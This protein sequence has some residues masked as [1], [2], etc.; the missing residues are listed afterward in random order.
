MVGGG[1]GLRIVIGT[2][3]ATEPVVVFAGRTGDEGTIPDKQME[4]VDLNGATERRGI[5]RVLLAE[6]MMGTKDETTT[7]KSA[8][9]HLKARNLGTRNA[10]KTAYQNPRRRERRPLSLSLLS[11]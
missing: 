8:V 1:V 3:S 4:R 11:P 7:G 6:I 10:E 5:A 2:D 9:A